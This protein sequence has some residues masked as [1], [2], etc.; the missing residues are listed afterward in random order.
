MSTTSLDRDASRPP[1]PDRIIDDV[2]G[3]FSMGFVGGFLWN[4]AKG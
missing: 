4:F 2:G 1:A 3:A